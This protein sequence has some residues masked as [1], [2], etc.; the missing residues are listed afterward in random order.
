[1]GADAGALPDKPRTVHVAVHGTAPI[2]HITL[3]RNNVDVRRIHPPGPAADVTVDLVD[4]DTLEEIMPVSPPV[5]DGNG[6]AL[7]YYYVRVVQADGR[8]AWSS[9]VW[10]TVP[11]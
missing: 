6:A 2:A 4:E 3:V 9:P 5:P 7:V 1:M 10:F 11:N 8:T